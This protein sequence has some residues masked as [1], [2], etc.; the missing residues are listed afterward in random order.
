MDTQLFD[1]VIGEPPASTVDVGGIVRRENRRGA[2]RRVAG[3]ATAVVSLS[4]AT[5][6][7]LGLTG[8]TGA[9]S[10]PVAGG[11]ASAPAAPDE[12]FALVADNR[13]S[14]SASAKRLG[15]ALDSAFR[16]EAPGAKWIFNPERPGQTGRDGVP[17]TLSYRVVGEAKGTPQELFHGDSGVL[18]DGRK[19]SLHLGVNATVGVSEDGTTI[20]RTLKCPPSGQRK[21]TAGKAP[22][23]A[24]TLFLT[25][26]SGGVHVDTCVVGLPGGRSLSITH[27]DNFGADGSIRVQTGMPLTETQVKAIAFDVAAQIKAG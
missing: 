7:G 14:A 4:V 26:A 2:V 13:E 20:G 25:S 27:T 16:K 11:G 21:C 8:G 5:A 17:P 12:R 3:L 9:S 22:S 10:P 23:G 24:R 1:E 19:G 18:N 15:A 6:I